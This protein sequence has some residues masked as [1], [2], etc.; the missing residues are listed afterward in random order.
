[1]LVVNWAESCGGE[2]A[3]PVPHGQIQD[4][5]GQQPAGSSCR[6]SLPWLNAKPGR[7]PA[8]CSSDP[9]VGDLEGGACQAGRLL[10]LEKPEN[11]AGDDDGS[12]AGR[13]GTDMWPTTPSR[14][15]VGGS[16]GNKGGWERRQ[17]QFAGRSR[18]PREG[19]GWRPSPTALVLEQSPLLTTRAWTGP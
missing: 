4:Q 1:M 3:E 19:D 6:A 5:G 12:K 15:T 9:A 2:A 14:S 7:L 13:R 17:R 16:P 18:C 11:G 10:N 8:A